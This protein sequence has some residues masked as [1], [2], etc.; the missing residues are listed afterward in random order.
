LAVVGALS[1]VLLQSVW[2]DYLAALTNSKSAA[3]LLYS[4]SDIAL[5]L[6]PVVAYIGRTRS[7][8]GYGSTSIP[9]GSP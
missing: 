8:S 9:A 2:L 7:W 1:A 5:L 4:L 6:I 3:G